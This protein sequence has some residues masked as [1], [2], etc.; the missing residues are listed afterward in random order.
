MINSKVQ[1][2]AKYTI[3]QVRKQNDVE[4]ERQ[5]KTTVPGQDLSLL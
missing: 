1:K 5:Q 4:E 3:N 2:S